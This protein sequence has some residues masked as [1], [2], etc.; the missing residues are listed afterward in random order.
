LIIENQE[1]LDKVR[2]FARSVGAEAELQKQLD[3]SR[4][5]GVAHLTVRDEE[6]SYFVDAKTYVLECEYVRGRRDGFFSAQKIP[7][8]I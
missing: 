7:V 3:F 4:L 1:H 8:R 5:F 6:C 2:E